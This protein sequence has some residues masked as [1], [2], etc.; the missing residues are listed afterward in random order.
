MMLLDSK[1]CRCMI[2]LLYSSS[3]MANFTKAMFVF[4]VPLVAAGRRQLLV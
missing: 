1:L 2:C 3:S 4:G